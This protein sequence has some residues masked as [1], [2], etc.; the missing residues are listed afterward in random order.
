[1]G[2]RAPVESTKYMFGVVKSTT[3]L[4]REEV[5]DRLKGPGDPLTATAVNGTDTLELSGI[6]MGAEVAVSAGL[7]AVK[8]NEA[9]VA[10]VT[11]MTRLADDPLKLASPA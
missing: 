2:R 4:A 8:L 11:V 3:P 1:M 7:S 9:G 10:A 6:C 5:T